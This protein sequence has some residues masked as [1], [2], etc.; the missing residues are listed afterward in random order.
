MQ[1]VSSAWRCAPPHAHLHGAATAATRLQHA[2]SKVKYRNMRHA[3]QVIYASEGIA[4]FYR[5][6][7]VN[8]VKV[9][10]TIAVMFTTNELLK[11]LFGL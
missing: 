7:W 10:P 4:G 11:P 8:Q 6:L 9:V 2:Q 5:G 3:C 1:G